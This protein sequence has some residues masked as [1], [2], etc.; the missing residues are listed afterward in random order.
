MTQQPLK[1]WI[2]NL[3]PY[4]IFLFCSLWICN[5]FLTWVETRQG[6]Q[7]ADPLLQMLP[8]IRTD[9][10]LFLFVYSAVFAAIYDNFRRPDFCHA[11]ESYAW[12]ILLRTLAM[13]LLP[14]DPPADMIVLRDPLVEFVGDSRVLTRD[15]FFSGHTATSFLMYLH[16]KHKHLK[17]MIGAFVVIIAV[18]VLLQKVHYAIDVL[19]APFFAYGAFRFSGWR[20]KFFR[21][22]RIIS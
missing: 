9:A 21:N 19:A 15:L 12:M 1:Q 20:R 4:A 16:T 18:G 11:M 14:L 7:I 17:T 13:W 8:T 3:I 2:Y 6:V 10:I 22:L 5:T